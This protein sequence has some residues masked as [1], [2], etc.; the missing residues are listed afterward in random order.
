MP[1]EIEGPQWVELVAFGR[2]WRMEVTR[3]TF[4]NGDGTPFV[5][6]DVAVHAD[7]KPFATCMRAVTDG[8]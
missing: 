1:P 2:R 5:V 4:R 6:E 7:G 3:I 8:T